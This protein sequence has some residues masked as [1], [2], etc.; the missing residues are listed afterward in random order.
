MTELTRAQA[1]L[2][3]SA[4]R[5]GLVAAITVP[6]RVVVKRLVALDLVRHR[7]GMIYTLTPSGDAAL[8][9]L[10]QEVTSS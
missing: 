8:E 9:E 7:H 10:R 4:D 1:I 2:L 3:K 5:Q 6:Q